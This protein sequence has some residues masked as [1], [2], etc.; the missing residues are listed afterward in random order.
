MLV[1]KAKSLGVDIKQELP[2][3]IILGAFGLN[4]MIGDA[5]IFQVSTLNLW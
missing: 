1:D 2:Q 5:M 4:F 3:K